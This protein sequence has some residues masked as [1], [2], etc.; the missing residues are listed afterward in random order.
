MA[1]IF[2]SV[3]NEMSGLSGLIH[4]FKP[5]AALKAIYKQWATLYLSFIRRRYNDLSRTG[6]EWPPLHPKTIERKN[7]SIILKDL[8]IL[9]NALFPGAAGNVFKIGND[10][11]IVG[12]SGGSHGDGSTIGNIALAHQTGAGNLPRREIFVVPDPKTIDRMAA[13]F[14]AAIKKAAKSTGTQ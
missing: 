11:A 14:S 1:E 4:I 8:G 6:G 5:G 9:F 12:I 13:A 7:S 3:K 10:G 2:I